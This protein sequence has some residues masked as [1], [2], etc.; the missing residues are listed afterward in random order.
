MST[1]PVEA[2]ARD[3]CGKLLQSET[4]QMLSPDR[5]EAFAIV[6]FA[7]GAAWALDRP[8]IRAI[9]DAQTDSIRARNAGSIS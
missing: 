9:A 7:L 2:A 8:D 1:N 6:A 4:A 5:A 3:Y